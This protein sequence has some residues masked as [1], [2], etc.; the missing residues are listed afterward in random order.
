MSSTTGIAGW[1]L[2]GRAMATSSPG[3]TKP[4]R[5]G[6]RRGHFDLGQ[7]GLEARLSRTDAVDPQRPRFVTPNL[8]AAVGVTDLV[9]R[10]ANHRWSSPYR[11]GCQVKLAQVPRALDTFAD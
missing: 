4:S 10:L 9:H 1:C 6:R 3:H 11:S 7:R 8:Q 2:P 5:P